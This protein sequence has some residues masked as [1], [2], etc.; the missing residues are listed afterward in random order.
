MDINDNISPK[1]GYYYN[2]ELYYSQ[3]YRSLSKAARDLLHCFLI[4]LRWTW[5]KSPIK[6]KKDY[7]NNS[8]HGG[9]SFTEVQFKELH[10]YCSATY[11]NARNQLIEV[12]FIKQNYRGGMCRGDCARYRLLCVD[13]VR[14]ESQRWRRY[15]EENW[16]DD[17][18]KLKK[19]MV[20]V[21]TQFKK[22]KSGRKTKATL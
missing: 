18:P 4:E 14:Q 20:G 22:G 19:Q 16:S 12:G 7:V 8:N 11:L 9:V 13:G 17:I 5:E 15:P 3:A 6:K 21:K 2:N 10:G 1:G